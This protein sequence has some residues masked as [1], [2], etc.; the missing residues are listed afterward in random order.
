MVN[1]CIVCSKFNKRSWREATD[2]ETVPQHKNLHQVF[3]VVDD[4]RERVAVLEGAEEGVN[5]GV[6]DLEGKLGG[7][8]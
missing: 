1:G 2:M 3:A 4:V 7:G 6:G 8:A 5:Q